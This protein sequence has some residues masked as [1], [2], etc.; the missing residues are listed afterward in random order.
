MYYLLQMQC[1]VTP[2]D[3]VCHCMLDNCSHPLTECAVPPLLADVT[4]KRKAIS[5]NSH[6]ML[7]DSRDPK[8]SCCKAVSTWPSSGLEMANLLVHS[9][10]LCI[11]FWMG[12]KPA[13]TI[14]KPI[15]SNTNILD[16]CHQAPK[17]QRWFPCREQRL[18][19]LDYIW[20]CTRQC[21]N[22]VHCTPWCKELPGVRICSP[23][24][25]CLSTQ[26]DL[27]YWL[28]ESQA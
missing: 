1:S 15:I 13:I 16:S 24:K 19:V 21:I 2:L 17:S 22:P 25:C 3:A 26:Q 20:D 27:N 6:L 9:E 28:C 23:R 4:A 12:D 10:N 11:P 14:G 18:Q 5:N 7:T 8:G